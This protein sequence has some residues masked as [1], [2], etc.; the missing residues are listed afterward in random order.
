MRITEEV[1]LVGSGATFGFGL[2][3]DPDCHIFLIDGGDE[4]ALIDCGMAAGRS[5]ER[6]VANIEREGLEL[7]RLRTLI[8]THYHMD[9][10]GGAAR[11]KE[12]FGLRVAAPRDA[13]PTL[14]AGDE[15]AVALDVAKAAG[16]YAADYRFEPVEVDHELAE[17]DR[18]R[19]GNLELAVY[20]TPGHCDG[21]AS[22]LLFGRERRYLFAGDAVFHGGKVVLQNIH[23]CSIQKSA[24]S[25][26]KLAALE[27]ESLLPSHAAITVD[28]GMR[29]VRLAADSCNQ[30]FVPKNL[31]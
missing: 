6:I 20:D 25:I 2:S 1:Y 18:F 11:F 3:D 14:R 28:D 21:H 26:R 22:Y 9:H 5:V 31:V 16:F 7:S 30:L 8:L 23:D 10:A 15:R 27:F 29:H 19:V 12:R 17:G 13:A 24:D 4:L